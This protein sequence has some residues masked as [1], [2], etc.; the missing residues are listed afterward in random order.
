MTGT[1]A[2]VLGV[3]LTLLVSGGCDDEGPGTDAGDAR[4]DVVADR[5]ADSGSAPV[6]DGGSDAPTQEASPDAWPDG[7]GTDQQSA[8]IGGSDATPEALTGMVNP[9]SGEIFGDPP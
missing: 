2:V 8:E 4:M 1:R 5:P 7:G 3:G 9:D 6:P